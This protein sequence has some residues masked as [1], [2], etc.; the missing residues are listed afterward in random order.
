[1]ANDRALGGIIFLGSLLGIGI[2]CWL[3]FISPWGDL[4]IKV[5]ALLAV[6]M[7]LL[8]IAW[9]GYTLATTTP[10]MP[11]ENFDVDTETKEEEASK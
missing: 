9:I 10:P 7:V 2:Y 5:S 4:T 11:L 8:I 6:G 1:M 3:L